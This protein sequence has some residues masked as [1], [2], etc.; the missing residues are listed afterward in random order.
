MKR[1]CFNGKFLSA[2]PTGV[3]RVAEELILGIDEMLVADP[4]LAGRYQWE[5]LY[6]KDAAREMD[7]KVVKPRLIGMTRWQVWEQFE[8]PF[9]LRDALLV[10]LCNLSPISTANSITM[11]HD[12]QTFITPDSYSTPFRLWY[13][14]ALPTIGRR[15]R[16]ILTVSEFSKDQLAEYKIAKSDKIDVVYNGVDHVGD[17]EPDTSI[18]SR[19][20]LSDRPFAVGLANTQVHKNL[21]VVMEAFSQ[22]ELSDYALVLFGSATK[23]KFEAEGVS[24]PDN[25]VFAGFVSENELAGLYQEA[26]MIVFPSTTEG[27]GLPPLEA[28]YLGTPAICAPCGSLP[29]VCGDAAT[30]ADADDA[31]AWKDA[32]LAHFGLKGE[33]RDQRVAASKALA[34]KFRWDEASKQLLE[35]ILREAS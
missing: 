5:V 26:E 14:F 15:N 30:Y 33:E 27:F 21:K 23:A 13:Q 31:I 24:V 1:I 6:P 4:D 19:L 29:E 28:M 16:R 25:V 35:I 7:L 32:I 11:I 22:A 9:Y 3:H 17:L 20:G 12:A 2:H 8:L 34:A 10:N 18:V